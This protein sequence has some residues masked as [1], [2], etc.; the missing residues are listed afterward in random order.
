MTS[1]SFKVFKSLDK[2]FKVEPPLISVANT[3]GVEESTSN[4]SLNR[5]SPKWAPI[6][7][8]GQS[9]AVELTIP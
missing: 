1:P 4:K 2:E 6:S 3:F 8:I 9:I 5:I 7:L